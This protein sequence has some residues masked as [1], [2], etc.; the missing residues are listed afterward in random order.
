VGNRPLALFVRE[1]PDTA[2]L[3]PPA[4]RCES[5]ME[6]TS[7]QRLSD[8]GLTGSPAQLE[9]HPRRRQHKR[10]LKIQRLPKPRGAQFSIAIVLSM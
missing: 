10:F 7:P 1:L 6:A 3:A 8:G 2:S 5:F 9:K 4:G